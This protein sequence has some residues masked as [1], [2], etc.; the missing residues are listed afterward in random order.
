MDYFVLESIVISTKYNC[1]LNLGV[2]A[3]EKQSGL[4]LTQQVSDHI[5][6]QIELHYVHSGDLLSLDELAKQMKISST[7]IRESFRQ[8]QLEGLVEIVPGKGAYV[9]RISLGEI[10]DLYRL[11][12]E[13]EVEATRLASKSISRFDLEILDQNLILYEENLAYPETLAVLDRQFHYIVIEAANNRYLETS[14]KLL[15]I[16]MGLLRNPAYADSV[17]AK[18]TLSEHQAIFE[19][20]KA[21]DPDRSVETA[22]NHIVNA[23][24]ERKNKER[25]T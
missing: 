16:K 8:L 10:D 23:R 21:G 15:R 19:A 6:D 13:M 5:R 3:L 7:P 22:G 24:T 25:A 17:R 9:A 1:T 14:L 11:R 12:R 2:G 18:Q 4:S 20:L